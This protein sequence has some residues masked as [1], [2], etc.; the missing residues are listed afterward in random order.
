MGSHSVAVNT[1]THRKLDE[2]SCEIVLVVAALELALRGKPR[3]NLG[4]SSFAREE[5]G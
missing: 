4:G 3:R 5:A 2:F 1:Q